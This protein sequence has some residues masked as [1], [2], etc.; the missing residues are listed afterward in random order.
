MLIEEVTK[1]LAPQAAAPDCN[2]VDRLEAGDLSAE[3]KGIA[4]SFMASH[5][6]IDRAAALGANLLIAHEGL[7]YSH[8]HHQGDPIGRDPVVLQ[9]KR[10]LEELGLAVYRCHDGI[11]RERPDGITAGLIEA[12]GWESYVLDHRSATALLEIPPMTLG[13]IAALW[14]RKLDLPFVRVVGD[15]AMLCRKAGVLAGYRGG[16][17]LAIPLLGDEG[18][19]LIIAG[20]GP[21]WETPEYVRDAAYQG[22]NQA[23][24]VLGHGPS[25]IPGMKRLAYRLQADYPGIPV[26][27]I[28]DEPL[29]QLI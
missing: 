27:F 2:T 17:E 19:D 24:I 4:V 23:L 10:R 3:V 9:K 6:V 8:R 11:H 21:E 7:F 16:G 22:R 20:E 25:E 14:K 18:A 1:R 5:Q 15:P 26:F 12:V 28:A 13:D 29:F